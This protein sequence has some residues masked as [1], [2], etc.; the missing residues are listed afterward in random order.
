ML[1]LPN[2]IYDKSEVLGT[3][4]N[5][6]GCLMVLIKNETF[7]LVQIYD[8]NILSLNVAKLSKAVKITFKMPEE[9]RI[10]YNAGN[11]QIRCASRDGFSSTWATTRV[12]MGNIKK[13]TGEVEC[14]ATHFT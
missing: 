8:T 4:A 10:K 3:L 12:S 5:P 11:A 6:T 13:D 14:L 1:D 9:M 7:A 2:F